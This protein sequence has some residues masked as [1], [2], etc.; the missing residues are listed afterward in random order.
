M[1][2]L[3]ASAI[4]PIILN[5]AVGFV[6]A[7]RG[8]LDQLFIERF[9]QLTFR[10]FIPCLLFA[11]I[12]KADVT[13][14]SLA[15]YWSGYFIPLLI[16]FSFIAW[17]K[18]SIAALATAYANTVMIGLSLILQVLGNEGLNI[19]IAVVSLNSLTLF[20][21]YAVATSLSGKQSGRLFAGLLNTLRNPI[22]LSLI[23]GVSLNMLGVPIF[24]SL[25][26]SI[27]LAGQAGLPCALLILG[28][29]LASFTANTDKEN[30]LWVVLL[31]LVKLLV[32]P[33]AVLLFSRFVLNLE[34][35]V[36]SV[37]V[38]LAACP[39]GINSLPFAQGRAADRQIVSASIFVSTIIAIFT[40]PM[41]VA[42]T[43]Q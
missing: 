18:S 40:L 11:S 28:A 23:S 6:L 43:I 38:L 24:E 14:T 31:C 29:T 7:T 3:V 41:W 4:L 10:F 34:P 20:F 26:R 8:F 13:L 22:I 32:I 9:S 25:L 5:A 17:I 35:I 21:A 19:A 1:I 15:Q 39:C 30:R 36:T 27:E 33:A 37:L 12:Y 16:I 2:V 42:I